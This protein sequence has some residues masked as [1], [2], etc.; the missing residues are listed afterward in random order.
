M[1]SGGRGPQWGAGSQWDQNP[2]LRVLTA[3]GRG[4]ALVVRLRVR[5][6]LSV[7]DLVGCLDVRPLA[8]SFAAHLAPSL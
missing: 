4:E 2:T 6:P 8:F 5:R 3:D 1:G 7:L